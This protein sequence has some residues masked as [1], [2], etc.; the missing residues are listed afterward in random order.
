M[1]FLQ[2]YTNYKERIENMLGTLLDPKV[3]SR[4]LSSIKYS[5]LGGGKRLRPIL[6]LSVLGVYNVEPTQND[7]KSACALECIHTYSLIH[8]DLP[9]MDNDDYRRGKLTNHKAY[10]EATAILAGDALLNLAAEVLSECALSDA[11]YARIMSIM[12]KN[13]G[14]LGMIGGQATEL[15]TD[16]QTTNQECINQINKLKTGKLIESALVCGAIAADKDCDLPKWSK[17]ADVFGKAFQLCD[18]ILDSNGDKDSLM[19][20]LGRN[21][22]NK[23]LNEMTN[24]ALNI[25]NEINGNTEFIREFTSKLLLRHTDGL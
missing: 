23:L 5:L 4:L 16:F 25:L 15:A 19:H 21:D 9:A 14:A 20:Y 8:D 12:F 10:D 24:N 3:Q 2:T 22:A 7:V 1:T 18:D 11:K 17:F 6:F 13:S